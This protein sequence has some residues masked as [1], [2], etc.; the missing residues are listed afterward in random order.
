MKCFL[1]LSFFAVSAKSEDKPRRKWTRSI[2]TFA[3]ANYLEVKPVV[4]TLNTGTAVIDLVYVRT[5]SSIVQEVQRIFEVKSDHFPLSLTVLNSG[6]HLNQVSR[7]A[8]QSVMRNKLNYDAISS[9]IF[10][11]DFVN[12]RR[13]FHG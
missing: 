1:P 2:V 7:D 13:L 10:S 4:T 12:F 3:A 6:Y 8:E 9:F 11:A 5:G